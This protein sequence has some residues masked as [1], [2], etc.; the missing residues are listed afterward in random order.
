[1]IHYRTF[2][3]TD[4]PGLVTVWNESLTARGAVPIPTPVAL[5]EYVFAKPYFDPAGLVLA[6]DDGLP[7]GFAH[8]G[9]GTEASE[10]R[11]VRDTGVVCIVAVRP[12]YR[13]RGIG[14]ELLRR[15]ESYLTERGATV[16]CAGPMSPLNPFYLGLYGGS[17]SAG[18]LDSDVLAQGFLRRWGYQPVQARLVFQRHLTGPVAATDPRFAAVRRL[19]D[20]LAGTSHGPGTWWHECTHGPIELIKVQLLD[21]S[22]QQQAARVSMWEMFGFCQRWQAPVIGLVNL[23]VREDLRRQ[24]LARFLV[25]AVLRHVQEQFFTL[26]EVQAPQTNQ[27]AVALLR[28]LGFTQVDTGR[29]Y[30]KT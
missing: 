11:L 15:C 25:T 3:N 6:L 12:A 7:V 18:F 2:R 29:L 14:S 5:E 19:Y 17:D 24:G 20:V 22:T 4:P 21:R 27:A 26:V 30:Q 13:R 23:E 1:L 28:S 9:F 10:S 16:L 8:A